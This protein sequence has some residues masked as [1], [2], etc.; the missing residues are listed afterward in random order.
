LSGIE[1]KIAWSGEAPIHAIFSC[2]GAEDVV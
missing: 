1:E 2:A